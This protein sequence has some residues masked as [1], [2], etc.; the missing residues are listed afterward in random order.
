MQFA[1]YRNVHPCEPTLRMGLTEPML[2][3]DA[4][5]PMLRTESTDAHDT[6]LSADPNEQKL[7]KLKTL[8]AP[9][10]LHRLLQLGAHRRACVA[11]GFFFF[12]G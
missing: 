3:M 10:A 6:R 8:A 7:A 5:D 9:N 1:K 2:S 4:V 11:G 12:V